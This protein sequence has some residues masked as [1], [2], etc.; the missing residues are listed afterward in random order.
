MKWGRAVVVPVIPVLGGVANRKQQLCFSSFRFV[1]FFP[2]HLPLSS[3]L[4]HLLLVAL[5]FERVYE[6]AI[7]AFWMLVPLAV[8]PSTWIIVSK[9][10]L[11]SAA[12]YNSMRFC[13][14]PFPFSSKPA[15]T[16]VT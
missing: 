13:P 15:D 16:D 6:Q 12:K 4:T 8:R 5:W 10:V 14:P 9:D 3:G 11:E 2:T 1:F 7:S